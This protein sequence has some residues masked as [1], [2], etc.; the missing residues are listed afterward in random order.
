MTREDTTPPIE[1][2]IAGLEIEE[3]VQE[4]MISPIKISSTI[5]IDGKEVHKASIVKRMLNSDEAQSSSDRLRR[6]RGYTKYPDKITEVQ[7]DLDLDDCILLGD[8]LAA[9]VQI[10]SEASLCILKIRSIRDNTSKKNK[11]RL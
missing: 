6:V 10:E 7:S 5:D 8:T 2:N 1:E 3:I 9:K 11:K 4:E